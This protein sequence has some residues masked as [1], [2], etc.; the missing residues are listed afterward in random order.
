MTVR[1]RI[2]AMSRGP[3][4]LGFRVTAGRALTALVAAVLTTVLLSPADTPPAAA[5]LSVTKPG[6][7]QPAAATSTATT[8]AEGSA[9]A[10]TSAD[11]EESPDTVSIALAPTTPVLALSSAEASFIVQISNNSEE[12]LPAT[13][14]EITLHPQ[15]VTDLTEL[16]TDTGERAAVARPVIATA[17]VPETGPGVDRTVTVTVPRDDLPLTG[18]SDPGVYEV[19]AQLPV[20]ASAAH[21]VLVWEGTGF[22]QQLPISIVVPM[23]LPERITGVPTRSQIT[24]LLPQFE[25]LL[26]SA[27]RTHATLAIDPRIIV[28]VRVLGTAAPTPARDFL[29]RLAQ[30]STPNFL[31]QFADADPAVEAALGFDEL[32]QPTGFSYLTQSGSFDT[33]PLPGQLLSTGEPAAS[34]APSRPSTAELMSWP[35]GYAGAWPA[36]GQVDTT[37]VALLQRAGVQ[38]II[39]SSDNVSAGADSRLTLSGFTGV[40]A[41]IADTDAGDAARRLLASAATDAFTASSARAELA[42]RLALAGEQRSGLVLALDRAVA[43][44]ADT[45]DLIEWVAALSWVTAIDDTQLISSSGS[46]TPASPN[47]ERV[48]TLQG[49]VARSAEIDALAPLLVTPHFLTEY[50][51]VRLMSAFATRYASEESNFTSVAKVIRERDEHLLGGVD[52]IPTANTQLVASSSQLPVQ[53]HNF[54]P[55][56]ALVSLHVM[57]LSAALVVPEPDFGARSITPGG[58]TTV[59]VP[60]QTR[61]SSG[62]SALIAQVSDVAEQQVFSTQQLNLTIR[63]SFETILLSSLGALAALLL[64]FGIWRSIRRRRQREQ[65]TP[66]EQE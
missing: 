49:V 54:L 17:P 25:A 6:V 29:D 31:L 60:V 22:T 35:R 55:F 12:T 14:V 36:A 53:L 11:T 23:V 48:D 7:T 56:E 3:S 47:P 21:T 13:A 30:T 46:L 9:E 24:E 62:E 65:L 8:E 37:T 40:E 5:T 43:A 45:S 44:E 15:R 32:V 42:A 20:P 27:E 52:V 39:M 41:L 19:T 57:P 51:R 28:G 4:R 50:Q 2:V 61:V 10:N 1:P 64:G 18:E 26:A 33:T 38:R 66:G 16:G 63:S 59:L 58:N 34:R